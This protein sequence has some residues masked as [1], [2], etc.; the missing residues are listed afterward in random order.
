MPSIVLTEGEMESLYGLPFAATALYL[1]LRRR[2]DFKTGRVGA[3]HAISWQ[4]VT[5]YLYVAGRPGIKTV[6]TS[7]WAAMRTCGHLQRAGLVNL[8]SN[9]ASGRL[10]FKL[11]QAMLDKSVSNKAAP[12]PQWFPHKKSG[13]GFID[14]SG[15][16]ST[17]SRKPLPPKAAQ[18]Q[19]SDVYINA[20][21]ASVFIEGKK[22]I[23]PSELDALSTTERGA[24]R[25][26][27]KDNPAHQGVLD[28]LAGMMRTG[29]IRDAMA[30]FKTLW[31]DHSRGELIFSHANLIAA[32][33]ELAQVKQEMQL[34]P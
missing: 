11:P 32:E 14:K 10:I 16:L 18:H 28:E 27:L 4:G 7:R 21:A 24:L 23:F 3:I 20:A 29:K 13:G 2:M 8:E 34:Q 17:Q 6:K 25:R 31:K 19:K 5:E 1:C 30:V 33:R 12:K 9:L 26:T 22:L 15:D